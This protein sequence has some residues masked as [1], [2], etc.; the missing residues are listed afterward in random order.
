MVVETM[1]LKYKIILALLDFC[2]FLQQ[3]TAR[4]GNFDLNQ[5]N[6]H[7]RTKYKPWMPCMTYIDDETFSCTKASFCGHSNHV[8]RGSGQTYHGAH[9]YCLIVKVFKLSACW[10]SFNVL[11]INNIYFSLPI[12]LCLTRPEWKINL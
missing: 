10:V 12:S 1:L 3:N 2:I 7:N 6:L 8:T 11:P 5:L 4:N 9:I